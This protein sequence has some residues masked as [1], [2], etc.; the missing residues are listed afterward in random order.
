MDHSLAVTAIIEGTASGKIYVDD[1]TE[2][3]A[4]LTWSKHRIFAAG[5]DSNEEFNSVL[6]GKFVN[7]IAPLASAAG[8]VDFC[9][10]YHPRSWEKQVTEIFAEKFPLKDWRQY[11]TLKHLRLEWRALIPAGCTIRPVDNELLE[12]ADLKN[13]GDLVTEIQSERD[14]IEAF[15]SSGFGFCLVNGDEI[16]SWCLSEYNSGDRCEIGIETVESYRRRGYA[17]LIASAL[18]EYA[19]SCGVTH[20]GWHC[21]ASNVGSIALAEKVGFGKSLEYPVFFAR[22]DQFENYLVHGWFCLQQQGAY[23]E[24]AEWYEKAFRIGE[25]KASAYYDAAR[26]WALAGEADAAY[27]NLEH[28]FAKGWSDGAQLSIDEAFESLRYTKI[29]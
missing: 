12:Q 21:W 17:T 20:I 10:H 7:E 25:A 8:R 15:L 27:R 24:A 29:C 19:L 16:A 9:F 11:L 22:F 4:A 28:A 14:S 13:L 3:T 2:P 5:N 23:R 18:V 6:N 26:A 1:P